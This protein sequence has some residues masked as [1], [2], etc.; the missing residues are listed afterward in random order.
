MI[1]ALLL[2]AVMLLTSLPLASS[3]AAP[4]SGSDE[5]VPPP[6][7]YRLRLAGLDE[8]QI[9]GLLGVVGVTEVARDDRSITVEWQPYNDKPWE[10]QQKWID[11]A[12]RFHDY[13]PI[14]GRLGK[15]QWTHGGQSMFSTGIMQGSR[16]L[17]TIMHFTNFAS[18]S[19]EAMYLVGNPAP[20]PGQLVHEML[21]REIGRKIEFVRIGDHWVIVSRSG[22]GTNV[23]WQVSDYWYMRIENTFDRDMVAAYLAK[24]GSITTPDLDLNLDRWI[25][26]EIRW[27]FESVDRQLVMPIKSDNP[28]KFGLSWHAEDI[29]RFTP[30]QLTHGSV[31]RDTP[32]PEKWQWFYHARRFL[33]ANLGNFKLHDDESRFALIGPDRYDPKNPPELPDFLVDPPM[34][35]GIPGATPLDDSTEGP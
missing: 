13:I 16:G 6:P 19:S 3:E 28:H 31:K 17:C 20:P 5:V 15:T 30:L 25:D 27:R 18:R 22:Y 32:L 9:T 21:G 1:R 7:P 12:Q 26:N 2:L 10:S 4:T 23:V 14:K 29:Y 34:P 8:T 33:W 11:G 24:F 35:A